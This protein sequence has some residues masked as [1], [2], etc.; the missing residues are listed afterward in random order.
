M[1]PQSHHPPKLCPRTGP[2]FGFACFKIFE[3]NQ[4]LWTYDPKSLQKSPKFPHCIISYHL[5]QIPQDQHVSVLSASRISSR[6]WRKASAAVWCVNPNKF[7]KL[8]GPISAQNKES[9]GQKYAQ[10]TSCPNIVSSNIIKWPCSI[11]ISQNDPILAFRGLSQCLIGRHPKRIHLPRGPR[12]SNPG[13]PQAVLSLVRSMSLKKKCGA[14][15]SGWHF[16]WWYFMF[17]FFISEYV[18]L[19]MMFGA[20]SKWQEPF[21]V[22]VVSTWELK[23]THGEWM[24]LSNHT[25]EPMLPHT[26]SFSCIYSEMM[27]QG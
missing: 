12:R 9:V 23:L 10:K 25:R 7:P 8:S 21:C 22:G 13:R 16:F 24:C 17:L 4:A 14:G 3:T 15:A 18:M 19:N 1:A 20:Q 26:R 5:H 27:P 11:Q 6:M 2:T